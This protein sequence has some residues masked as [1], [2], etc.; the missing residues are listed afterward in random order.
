MV[1][2]VAYG[3]EVGPGGAI[4]NVQPVPSAGSAAAPAAGGGEPL[5]SPLAGNVWKIM[6]QPGQQVESGDVVI[7]L[8]AMKMET[9]IR[10]QKGGVIGSILTTEGAA[11]QS[12]AP[13]LTIA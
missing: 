3:V 13:L 1:D 12:G 5:L 9:E 10:A 4:S 2:G 8:E 11:V 6:V 7:I